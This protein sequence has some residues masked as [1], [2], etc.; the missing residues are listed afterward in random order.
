MSNIEEKT[1]TGLPISGDSESSKQNKASSREL[2]KIVAEVN[3]LVSAGT[4][5]SAL[6][7]GLELVEE[8]PQAVAAHFALA[9]VYRASGRSEEAIR[10]YQ[11]VLSID[12]NHNPSQ[13][14]LGE[15][16]LQ[17]G[18]H[19]QAIQ[20]YERI[21]TQQRKPAYWA[22]VGLGTAYERMGKKRKAA[23]A[24][25]RALEVKPASTDLWNRI[26][27]IYE[28]T[29]CLELTLSVWRKQ[30]ESQTA[31]EE[32]SS[33]LEKL[34]KAAA[35]LSDWKAAKG[36]FQEAFS[37]GLNLAAV[38]IGLAETLR[39]LGQEEEAIRL[40]SQALGSLQGSLEED[41][42]EA[43]DRDTAEMPQKAKYF[44]WLGLL[45]RSLSLNESALISF[46][47]AERHSPKNQ[48][49]LMALGKLLESQGKK[50]ESYAIYAKLIGINPHSVWAWDRFMT[51]YRRKTEIRSQ[52]SEL[53]PSK[54]LAIF[55][56]NHLLSKK[57]QD[58]YIGFVEWIDF[59]KVTGWALNIPHADDRLAIRI[60]LNGQTIGT[61][62]TGLENRDIAQWLP[63]DDCRSGFEFLWKNARFDWSS[64]IENDQDPL[65]SIVIEEPE[66]EQ[67]HLLHRQYVATTNFY[68]LIE[69][70]LASQW[71]MDSDFLER[72]IKQKKLVN[73]SSEFAN[74]PCLFFIQHGEAFA[75]SPHPLFDVEFVA[76]KL[77]CLPEDAYRVY[78]SAVETQPE[79][80]CHPLF[81]SDFYL[82]QLRLFGVEKPSDS[83]VAHYLTKGW[84]QGIDPHPLFDSQYYRRL[85]RVDSFQI[86]PL[87]RYLANSG[88]LDGDPSPFFD[89]RHYHHLCRAVYRE[90]LREKPLHE[91]VLREEWVDPHVN[92]SVQSIGAI[93][94][95]VPLSEWRERDQS[96]SANDLIEI[97]RS[98]RSLDAPVMD[99]TVAAKNI[100][101]VHSPSQREGVGGR[102]NPDRAGMG[103]LAPIP[104][105]P[106]WGEGTERLQ[107]I[108]LSVIILN[109]NKPVH[110]ILSAYAAIRA[111]KSISHELIIIDNGSSFNNYSILTQYLN[112]F[113]NTRVIRL[114]RNRFFGEGNNIALDHASGASICFLNNDAYVGENT[115]TSLLSTLSED[116]NIGAVGPLFVLPD[117][118]LQEAG[119][120]VSSCGQ[121]IQVG[122]HLRLD[123]QSLEYVAN[124]P[125]QVDYISAAC[126]L[127]KRE[128]LNQIGGF[129]Y[130]FEPFYYEDTDLC[131][132]IRCLDYE[133]RLDIGAYVLH[134]ENT[135]TREFL[136]HDFISTIETNKRKFANRWFGRLEQ[137][138]Q[139]GQ[140]VPRAKA[141]LEQAQEIETAQ[142]A[143]VF[144][145]FA[146]SP[147]GGEKYIMTIA[148]ALSERFQTTMVFPE[149]HSIS[150]FRMVAED[151]GVAV[152]NLRLMTWNEAL[153]LPP[154]DLFV[155]MGN[156]IIPSVPAIGRRNFYHCQFPFPLDHVKRS[157][158]GQNISGYD[159]VIVNSNFTRKEVERQLQKYGLPPLPVRVLY[160]PC[161]DG[162]IAAR[163]QT[164]RESRS[165]RAEG[166]RLEIL[167]VGRFIRH[168]HN[169]RQDVILEIVKQLKAT[170]K[171]RER[172]LSC[173]LLGGVYK[174]D[175]S[176]YRG[177]AE[178][179]KA[180]GGITIGCNV[181]RAE[182]DAA[183]RNADI[184]LHATG[185]EITEGYSP[186]VLEHF[187]ISVVEA[188]S[189]GVIPLVYSAGGPKEIVEKI[190]IGAVF[191]DI[192][193][194]VDKLSAILEIPWAERNEMGIALIE[195]SAIFATS[196]F[197]E[198]VISL[199]SH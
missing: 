129:D 2:E 180:I 191:T 170:M 199:V 176:F 198:G 19:Q 123:R 132:R 102:E 112:A 31:P 99:S 192:G 156:E 52:Q 55:P 3:A 44:Y 85:L 30:L 18:D 174:S 118:S 14:R 69:K 4:M 119:G 196:R 182:I 70:D 159:Q 189:F 53:K 190:G 27:R 65:L 39:N 121:V 116:E 76:Q 104:T 178:T 79:C 127:V 6:E 150:R 177:I 136:S 142:R 86:P 130:I 77:G 48:S 151:L 165:T 35:S 43:H 1:Q 138:R 124:L 154:P 115:F 42:R 26:A 194:A 68:P 108:D 29:E 183:Y 160:P 173:T 38:T 57:E 5:D 23:D 92:I 164:F 58:G 158:N 64:L 78:L 106:R 56:R 155:A 32:R 72:Q 195:R 111:L 46:R 41:E 120:K 149:M 67:S 162:D 28:R 98:I 100:V 16:F 175:E 187:G 9:D 105:S 17:K 63:G 49:I 21:V 87:Q 90:R 184:Y 185:Y 95:N 93:C 145:P 60:M 179:G 71:L 169:K 66:K 133:L 59:E 91:F 171:E 134:F 40:L 25:R 167:N 157:E 89:E 144:S 163:I 13:G 172:H 11:N 135:S 181:E 114:E 80:S 12:S 75:L 109:Y 128:V 51:N 33:I 74:F 143:V 147:G 168:G 94:R 197:M 73:D 24:Y 152:A 161:W 126:L 113:P 186:H 34:G 62:S 10:S 166:K 54:N 110:T 83:L 146:L 153:R 193:E 188:M 36:Y 20:C 122:K 148:S 15:I 50:D 81:D 117:Y 37:L 47:F 61:V 137:G 141:F 22:L 8:F 84:L 45:Q 97:V 107:N 88:G 103:S 82:E 131:S 125:R 7:R 139:L 96:I 101:S 140:D